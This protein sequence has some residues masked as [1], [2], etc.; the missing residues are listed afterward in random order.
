M[1]APASICAHVYIFILVC[2]YIDDKVYVYSRR[3]L[4]QLSPPHPH[5]ACCCRGITTIR[6]THYKSPHGIPLDLLDRLMIISTKPYS[7]SELKAI[8]HIRCEEEDVEMTSSS[9]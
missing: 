9:S 6:G 1:C 4:A 5:P 8:L 2:R 3:P 7:E